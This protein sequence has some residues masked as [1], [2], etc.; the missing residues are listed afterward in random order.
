MRQP[1]LR[2]LLLEDSPADA[3][4]VTLELRHAGL[5]AVTQ[6]VDTEDAFVRAVRDFAPDV[7]LSDHSLAQFNWTAAL[8]L[9]PTIRPATRLIVVAGALDAQT[10]VDCL[11][12]GAEDYVLKGNLSRLRSAIDAAL[13]VRRPLER[14]SPRQLE[15]LRLLAQGYSTRE[16]ARRLKLSVKTI[17]THRAEAM[18]RLDIHEIPGLVRYAILASRPVDA[19]LLDVRLPTMSGLALYLAIVHRWPQLERR[20]AFMTA[21]P[22]AP[23]VRPWLEM[24][25]CTVFPKPFRFQQLAHWLDATLLARDRTAATS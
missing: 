10:V 6:R 1:T 2:I 12:A 11:K 8:R 21:E 15:V 16:I 25:H 24:H 20:I 5:D 9:L 19:V 23:D 7:V 17:E 13:A 4:L 3:E 14:L 22:D 18:K